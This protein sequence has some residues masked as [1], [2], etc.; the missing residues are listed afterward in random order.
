[1]NI[2]LRHGVQDHLD[3]FQLND[4][5]LQTLMQMQTDA[6]NPTATQAD[7]HPTTN[8]Q[9]TNTRRPWH[10][11]LAAAAVLLLG[12]VITW[13]SHYYSTDTQYLPHS[14]AMEAAKNHIKLKPLEVK[15]SVLAPISRYFT[16]LDFVPIQSNWYS[17]RGTSLLG[18]RYCS[19]GG[20]SAAQIRYQ[21]S[22]QQLQ[23][24]YEVGY[25]EAIYGPLPH[26][27][28]GEAPLIIIVKGVKT[29][30]WV[31]SDLLMVATETASAL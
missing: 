13:Q 19:I 21:D 18:A 14:I 28:R 15:A 3:Q 23:T 4:A 25:N 12:L 6:Q 11:S 9:K 22:Q 31:E 17:K 10:F 24:L 20:V 27:D 2:K 30:I 7:A 5:Q 16:E 1:M 29:E 26:I 8:A